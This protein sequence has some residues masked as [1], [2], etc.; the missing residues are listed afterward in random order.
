MALGRLADP[1]SLPALL[2][3]LGKEPEFFVQSNR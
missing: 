2:A 3:P 1:E